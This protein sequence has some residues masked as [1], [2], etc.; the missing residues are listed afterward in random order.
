MPPLTS[1]SG[2]RNNGDHKVMLEI[3]YAQPSREAEEEGARRPSSSVSSS[4]LSLYPHPD[5]TKPRPFMLILPGG[6][7][8]HLAWHEGE[9]VALWMRRLGMH[10][11]VLHYRTE[12]EIGPG[13][14]VA[15]VEDALRWIRGSAKPFRVDPGRVGLAGFSAGGHLAAVSTA[16]G[17]VKPDLLLLGYPVITLEEPYAHAGSVERLL[18]SHPAPEARSAWSADRRW[19][20]EAEAQAAALAAD[21]PDTAAPF[22]L[23]PAFVWTTADDASVPV[24]NSLLFA[25]ALSRAHI[26]FEL[27]VL[28]Q[29]RHGLGMS[30]ENLHC[31][32]WLGLCESWLKK[33]GYTDDPLSTHSDR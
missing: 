22:R 23:P 1:V 9:P 11:G 24:A 2:W 28:E 31:R 17:T 27:H 6:G 14:L 19:T 16:A 7:Y 29:G 4:R 8:R 21:G 33:Q 13:A 15:D 18:G 25:A 20:A 5:G 32:Q 10:A 3:E 26:P 12:G 30:G